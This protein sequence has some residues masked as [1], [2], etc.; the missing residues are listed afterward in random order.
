MENS[1]MLSG[2]STSHTINGLRAGTTYDISVMA[3]NDAG[4]SES[5]SVQQSTGK[6]MIPYQI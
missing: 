2:G 4:T 1:A 6:N 3:E 5:L